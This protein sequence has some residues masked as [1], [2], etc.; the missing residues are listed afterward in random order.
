MKCI[1]CE[2]KA[3]FL[4]A[5]CGLVPYCSSQC[6]ET[7]YQQYHND[8][9][10]WEVLF[11]SGEKKGSISHFYYTTTANSIDMV[12]DIETPDNAVLLRDLFT[13]SQLIENRKIGGL[14]RGH[15]SGKKKR[16]KKAASGSRYWVKGHWR[17]RRTKKKLPN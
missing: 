3:V 8:E 11:N 14:H 9:H 15:S 7:D 16:Y 10:H 5:H 17:K 13:L 6:K 4:C 1:N 2:N 12:E